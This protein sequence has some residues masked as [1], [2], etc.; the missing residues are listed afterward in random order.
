MDY[1]DRYWIGILVGLGI[2]IIAAIVI[3]A[4]IAFGGK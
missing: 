3:F 1:F 4:V 2:L